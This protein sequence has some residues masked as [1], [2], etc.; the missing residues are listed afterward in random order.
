MASIV[1]IGAIFLAL[2][3]T[4]KQLQVDATTNGVLLVAIPLQTANDTAPCLVRGQ[5]SSKKRDDYTYVHGLGGYKLHTRATT[6]VEARLICQEEGGHLAVINSVA[7]ADAVSLVFKKAE[8]ITGSEYPYDA[9]IGFH[10]LYREGEYVTIHGESLEKAGYDLWYT[11]QPN[12]LN[13]NQNCGGIH[14]NGRLNDLPCK[15][16]L[17]GFICE[18][19]AA[20]DTVHSIAACYLKWSDYKS[21]HTVSR[22]VFCS[23]SHTS[24][25]NTMSSALPLLVFGQAYFLTPA[26]NAGAVAPNFASIPTN[27]L[28]KRDDYTYTPGI[29]AHKV[30]TQAVSWS[31]AWAK[32]RDEGAHLAIINSQA[33][34]KLVVELLAKAGSVIGSND[35]NYAHIGF[36]DMYKKNQWVTIE[37]QSLFEAGFSEWHQGEP[38][39]KDGNERCGS[40]D[41]RDGKFNDQN[42]ASKITNFVCELR[43]TSLPRT[44]GY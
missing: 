15:G 6:W 14:D 42:C 34:S 32:C 20:R 25:K 24:R 29:G 27:D 19:P 40:I 38:N 7:E 2:A 30:H 39:N 11:N 18:V 21:H 44:I 37:G 17:F 13:N 33:E 12:N 16:Q 3:A 26:F 9:F 5:S 36:H 23:R 28:T 31:D 8:R 22:F 41:A 10:D 43:Q 1:V 4:V 35:P